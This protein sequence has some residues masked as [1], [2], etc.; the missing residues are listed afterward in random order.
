M[1]NK[2]SRGHLT[3]VERPPTDCHFLKPNGLC[4]VEIRRQQQPFRL[5]IRAFKLHDPAVGSFAMFTRLRYEAELC[6][7]HV[8]LNKINWKCR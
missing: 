5:A 8:E 3:V 7:F 1:R 6:G 4:R 2:L